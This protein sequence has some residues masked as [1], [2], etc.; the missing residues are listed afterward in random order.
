MS[1]LK[2]ISDSGLSKLIFTTP[3]LQILEI[4]NLERLTDNTLETLTKYCPKL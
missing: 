1:G 4:N 2:E 3:A